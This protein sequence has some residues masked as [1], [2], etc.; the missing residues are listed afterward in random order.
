M[1]TGG[2]ASRPVTITPRSWAYS[3]LLGVDFY[4]QA[5][6]ILASSASR[7]RTGA[8]G[9]PG[10]LREGFLS[11]CW[12]LR[13]PF[14]SSQE[15]ILDSPKVIVALPRVI[16]CPLESIRSFGC[17]FPPFCGII[18]SSRTHFRTTEMICGHSLTRWA[19]PKA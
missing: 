12:P 14:W 13:R 7:L 3:G 5:R 19:A 10:G 15:L 17:C 4:R 16:L 8:S 11:S 18:S 6:R 1:G 9:A 2:W